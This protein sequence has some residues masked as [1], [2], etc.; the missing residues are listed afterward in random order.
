MVYSC[1]QSDL[2][3]TI[4]QVRKHSINTL[5]INDSQALVGDPQ[6]YPSVLTLDPKTPIMDIRL[7]YPFGLIVGVRDIIARHHPLSCYLADS[8]HGA[9]PE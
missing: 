9:N 2:G 8:G 1:A 4:A 6:L 7:E 3:A 5:F